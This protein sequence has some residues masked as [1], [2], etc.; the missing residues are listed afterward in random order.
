MK[1]NPL[2]IYQRLLQKGLTPQQACGVLGNMQQE[3]NFQT[4]ALGF[5]GTGSLGLCQWL[6]PRKAGLIAFAQRTGR[7]ETD[8]TAQVDWIF[9]EFNKG[10]SKAYQKLLL[11]K[12]PA[13]AALAFSRYYERPHKDYAHN[14]NRV[15]WADHYFRMYAKP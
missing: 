2:L 13:E 12:T 8:W 6:G 1:A 9:V 7:S 14:P 3:S 11:S 5:D 10:E 4:H 15:K